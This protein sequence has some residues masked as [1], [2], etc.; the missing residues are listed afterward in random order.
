M[1]SEGTSRAD[2]PAALAVARRRIEAAGGDPD[3]VRIVAVTKGFGPDAVLGAL[4]AGLRDVGENYAQE[5]LTKA[6][7]LAETTLG[8]DALGA[9]GHGGVRWHFLGAVQR[10]KVRALAPLLFCWQGVARAV[11]GEAIAR[12]CPGASVLVEVEL[13]GDSSR[14]GCPPDEVP[15]LVAALRSCDLDVRGLMTVA[16]A[17]GGDDARQAFRACRDLA[18]RLDLPERSMGMSDDL[19]L[20][21]AEGTTMVRLGR[22]LFGDRPPRR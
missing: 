12:H 1:P 7:A 18:D 4:A 10:N 5:L 21:V 3:A 6:A 20:A 11:E 8:T 19:E 22:A 13:T 14:N 17:G 16:P 9:R 2:V 15:G